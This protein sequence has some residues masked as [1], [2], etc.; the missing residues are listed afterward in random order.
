MAAVG[1]AVAGVVVDEAV[2]DEV[3]VEVLLELL[4]AAAVSSMMSASESSRFKDGPFCHL[5]SLT[6][7]TKGDAEHTAG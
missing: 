4:Q 7:E 5:T 6:V 3:P 2:V 1:L